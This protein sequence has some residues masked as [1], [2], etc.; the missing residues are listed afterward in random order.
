V[1]TEVLQS[2]DEDSTTSSPKSYYI[3]S[4]TTSDESLNNA[5]GTLV[6]PPDD[7]YLFELAIDPA[8]NLLTV[9]H[10]TTDSFRKKI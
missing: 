1:I 9:D 2:D 7:L 4:G 6:Y 5:F 10:F 3:D 8:I